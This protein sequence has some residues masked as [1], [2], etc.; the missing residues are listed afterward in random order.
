M[1]QT[2]TKLQRHWQ[3]VRVLLCTLVWSILLGTILRASTY[4]GFLG[5]F[6]ERLPAHGPSRASKEL[7]VRPSGPS[8]SLRFAVEK[9]RSIRLKGRE[10][11]TP[12]HITLLAEQQGVGQ[13]VFQLHQAATDALFPTFDHAV[14]PVS[15]APNWGAMRT[16]QEWNRQYDDMTP[17]DFVPLP[18]YDPATLTIP[19]EGLLHPIVQSNIAI[20]TA[21][22]FYSTR[23]YGAYD[24]DAGE[25]SGT[26]PG[27]DLKLALDTPIAAI[28]GGRVVAV[29]QQ[30]QGLGLHII[31]EHHLGDSILYSLYGHLGKVTVQTGEDVFPGRIIGT[32]GMTGNTTAPHLHL[33]I[34][35]ES[36]QRPH[37]PYVTQSIPSQELASR[38]TVNPMPFIEQHALQ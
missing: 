14:P 31:I 7:S 19:L 35:R 2:L 6:L 22:L 18:A 12:V 32:V 21:K 28:A 11:A 27:V 25:F 8:I 26:H 34:D 16:P 17:R 23:Y 5:H 15:L 10:A 9:R 13:G 3:A 36:G 1:K 4:T 33:Q 37:V 38:V 30:K 20:I 29:L 24:L